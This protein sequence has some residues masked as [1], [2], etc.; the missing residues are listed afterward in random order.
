MAT[1]PGFRIRG[2]FYAYPTSRKTTDAALVEQ[3]TGLTAQQWTTRYVD[4]F[5]LDIDDE[6]VSSGVLAIA[7]S[8]AHPTW[9]RARVVEFMQSLDW[10]EVEPV[11]DP[12]EEDDVRPPAQQPQPQET[13]TETGETSTERSSP[14]SSPESAAAS[15]GSPTPASSGAPRSDTSPE[16]PLAL[17]K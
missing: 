8:R 15:N 9:S 5:D 6:V 7:I 2:R 4:S 3:V 17:A 10:D 12:V 16:A 13:E 11:G 14:P 1:E